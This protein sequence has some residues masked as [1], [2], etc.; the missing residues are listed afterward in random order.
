VGALFAVFSNE[1][2]NT[3]PAPE[4]L[5]RIAPETAA[6]EATPDRLD[7]LGE[8]LNPPEL[9]LDQNSNPMVIVDSFP[10][11]AQ[12]AITDWRSLEGSAGHFDQLV[13]L[14]GSR[15]T[16]AGVSAID[17]LIARGWAGDTGLGMRLTDVFLARC[18]RIVGHARV[19]LDRPDVA[20]AVHPN[21][22]RSGWEAQLL[23]GHLPSCDNDSLSAWVVV[24]GSPALLVP[25]I[26]R[27][28]AKVDR[29]GPPAVSH[30]S[31]QGVIR[32]EAYAAPARVSFEILASRVN[33]RRCGSTEC[34]VVGQIDQGTY[35]GAVLENNGEWSLIGF[36]A[37]QGWLFNG[38]YRRAE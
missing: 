4:S 34:P 26:G 20:K 36:G 24:P 25:L 32:P 19:T 6:P 33:L 1:Q 17:L 9:D 29:V 8:S 31:A 11:D 12:A 5:S 35:L 28:T 10:P 2:Q 16:D 38:L 18:D 30:V 13:L 15:P 21:L 14:D 23:A 27:H 3:V 7:D 22:V 37:H